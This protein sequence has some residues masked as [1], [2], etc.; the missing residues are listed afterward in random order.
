M[1]EL[2]NLKYMYELNVLFCMYELINLNERYFV[3]FEQNN[4]SVI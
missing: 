2:I 3:I 1:Y 4:C